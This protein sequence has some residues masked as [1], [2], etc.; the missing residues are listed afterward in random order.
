MLRDERVSAGLEKSIAVA[1]QQSR[2]R[3]IVRLENQVKDL[4]GLLGEEFLSQWGQQ[5]GTD[6]DWEDTEDE[7][8]RPS[9]GRLSVLSSRASCTDF[10]TPLQHTIQEVEQQLLGRL[11]ES[12][13]PRSPSPLYQTFPARSYKQTPTRD[14]GW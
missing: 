13:T 9:F 4:E 8:V 10:V 7:E 1:G 11:A 5:L 2:D 6:F 3:R 14:T 12:T